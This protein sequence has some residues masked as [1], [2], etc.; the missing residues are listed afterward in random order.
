MQPLSAP[1]GEIVIEVPAPYVA[2]MVRQTLF[3]QFQQETYTRGFEVITSLDGDKQLAANRALINGLE[4]HYDSL[5]AIGARRQ[6][7]RRLEIR[8]LTGWST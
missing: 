7:S 6:L 8:R 5:M 2:E 1:S 3:E 4:N